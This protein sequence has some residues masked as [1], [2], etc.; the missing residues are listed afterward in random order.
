MPDRSISYE[1]RGKFDSFRAGLAAT[2]KGVRDFG[3]DLTGLD[4]KGEK[5][6]QSFNELGGQAGRAGLALGAAFVGV[7]TKAANFEQSMSFVQAATHETAANMK[8]LEQAALDAGAQTAF[9]ATEAAG[10]IENLAKAGVATEDILAGGLAGALDLA[11]AGGIDVATAAE[12]A[13]TAMTQ[14]GLAGEDI[15]HIADLL[16][17]GAGKAQGEVTDLGAALNQSGLIADQVGLTIEET[18]GSLAAFASAGLLGSDAGTS[19]K[20]MLGALTPNSKEARELMDRLGISAYDA[21]GSFIGMAEFAGVL[22]DALAGMSDKQRQATLET[23]FGSDA[24]RAAALLYEQGSEGIQSWID[25]T[26]DSGYAA[27]TAAIRM[28]NLKGDLEELGGALETAFI[29][30]GDGQQ[31]FLRGLTQSLTDLVNAFNDLPDPVKSATG[32]LLGVAA[33]GAGAFWF[34]SKAVTTIAETRAALQALGLQAMTTRQMLAAAAAGG[35]ALTAISVTGV[36]LLNNYDTWQRSNEAAKAS[37]ESFEDLADALSSSNIGKFAD[38]LGINLDRLARDLYENGENGEYV[39]DVLDKLSEKTDGFGKGL[40]GVAGDVLPGY[41]SE[42][43]KAYEANSD[44][45]DI[46]KNNSDVLGR[47][48]KDARE[49]AIEQTGLAGAAEHLASSANLSA[50]EVQALSGAMDAAQKEARGAVEGF[51]NLSA[52]VDGG[53]FSFKEWLASLRE[54]AAA[55]RDFRQNAETAAERGLDQG[56]INSLQQLGPEGALQ[57]QYLANASDKELAAA[58]RAWRGYDHQANETID[59]VAAAIVGLGGMTATPNIQVQGGP[60]AEAELNRIAR[61]RNAVIRIQLLGDRGAGPARI[62]DGGI[63]DGGTIDGPRYPYG[64]KVFAYVAP[65]EEVI[66][67][68]FGQADRWRPLLKAINANRFAD[69]GTVGLADGGTVERALRGARGDDDLPRSLKAL[70]VELERATKAVERE[71][72]QREAL[73]DARRDLVGAVTS[74]LRSDIFGGDVWS[75]GS[76]LD[77][78]RADIANAR[79]L[80]RSEDLLQRKGVRGE[81]LAEILRK[82]VEDPTVAA[83]MAAMSRQQLGEY[84]R[85]LQQRANLTRNIGAEFGRDVYGHEIAK[86]TRELKGAN[87]RLERLERAVKAADRGNRDEHRE[88]RAAARAGAG[89]AARRRSRG[90]MPG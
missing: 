12:Q 28:D 61:E 24:V 75:T 83:S 44:L 58:N 79:S 78:L 34:T 17:A 90:R 57:L 71:R 8:L 29:G 76:P 36:D 41:T 14:F 68:R 54:S 85:L 51:L 49:A 10:A 1:F 33:V 59:S 52:G 62:N 64:D 37:A 73:V 18:T 42:T 25:K 38:D 77:V 26:N 7:A 67:N 5:M 47:A 43:N 84:Q 30:A 63:A 15:P 48:T 40:K 32:S 21:Q 60:Q 2:S 80:D 13:A 82:G 89:V 53:K 88:D 55:L 27:E 3:N 31:G 16:A 66:S 50:E 45:G 22:Q 20:T 87:A 35:V 81:A 11:A 70:R 69:G 65:G 56:L 46:I 19:F 39:T 86:Q 23:I 6:R 74:G 9:S 4:R 72:S